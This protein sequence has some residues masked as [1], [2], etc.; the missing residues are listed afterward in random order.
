MLLRFH[1][2]LTCGSVVWI[3]L[4]LELLFEVLIRP[5]DYADLIVSEKAFSPPTARN[6]N[7]FHLFFESLALGLFIPQFYCAFRPSICGERVWLGAIK[8]SIDAVTSSH[9]GEAMAGRIVLGLRFLRV[10]GLLRHWKQ[11]W[12]MHTFDESKTE[13]SK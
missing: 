13:S 10:F 1:G 7:R 6:I 2:R 9:L 3:I 12:L 11:M 8:A 4:C 5:P